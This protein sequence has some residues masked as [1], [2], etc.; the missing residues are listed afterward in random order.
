M[1]QLLFKL[2]DTDRAARKG[3]V[4][5]C[6]TACIMVNTPHTLSV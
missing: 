3:F 6:L 5:L 2:Y 4:N 1:K